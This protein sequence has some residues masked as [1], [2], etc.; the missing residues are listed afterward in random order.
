RRAARGSDAN[1]RRVAAAVSLRPDSR[2][3]LRGEGPGCPDSDAPTPD[4]AAGARGRWADS[5]ASHRGRAA[6][7]DGCP[8]RR[9]ASFADGCPTHGAP[10][11]VRDGRPAHGGFRA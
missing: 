8:T 7:T 4:A 1:A 10:A 9:P 2:G 5:R 6:F 3:D 11:A